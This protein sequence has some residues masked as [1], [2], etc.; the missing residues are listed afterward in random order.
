[1]DNNNRVPLILFSGGLDSTYLLQKKLQQ[2]DVEVLYV[3]GVLHEKKMEME[4]ERREK[5]IEFL[6]KETGNKVR[7]KHM[8]DLG[9]MPFGNMEDQAFTQPPMWMLGALMVSDV[10]KH[11]ELLIGYVSGDQVMPVLAH[12][13]SAWDQLQHICKQ[14]AHVPVDFPL[15]FDSK[16]HILHH[17][18]PDLMRLVWWCEMPKT[19]HYS[20][21]TS[22]LLPDVEA[23]DKGKI[24]PCNRCE[25]CH[26]MAATFFTWKRI[27]HKPYWRHLREEIK[28][29]EFSRK[30]DAAAELISAATPDGR[31]ESR[32]LE[33]LIEV[34]TPAN[35]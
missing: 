28:R 34:E 18:Y 35:T 29:M 14:H 7:K 21:P 3:R 22:Y 8:I 16:I 12:I 13:Q 15:R 6:E 17:M 31:M 25:A 2:G 11:T 27:T 33:E 1:M 26:R 23:E 5:I 9:P 20:N 30:R 19:R 24:R 10:R 4:Q 32:K